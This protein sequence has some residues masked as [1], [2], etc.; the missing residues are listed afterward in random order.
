MKDK[1]HAFTPPPHTDTA[2]CIYGVWLHC[3][4]C[5]SV[6]CDSVCCD[7]SVG[8]EGESERGGGSRSECD[9]PRPSPPLTMSLVLKSL[10][11]RTPDR[12]DVPGT[13]I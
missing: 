10:V 3:M 11:T 7:S 8:V 6:C 4:C 9:C 2:S 1:I 13:S 12:V 5:D